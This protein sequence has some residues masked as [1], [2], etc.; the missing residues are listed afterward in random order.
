MKKKKIFIGLLIGFLYFT[1]LSIYHWWYTNKEDV[2]PFKEVIEDEPFYEFINKLTINFN[3]TFFEDPKYTDSSVEYT[4]KLPDRVNIIVIKG[5]ATI[6][7]NK[8]G[9][10]P[11]QIWYLDDRDKY[12]TNFN[13][14]DFV[15]YLIFD[16]QT[17]V[18]CVKIER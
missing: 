13:Y 3:A 14:K 12:K 16:P 7:F 2:K 1:T 15:F 11:T 10:K 17:N 18:F 8:F 9:Y 5:Y 6:T 4:F